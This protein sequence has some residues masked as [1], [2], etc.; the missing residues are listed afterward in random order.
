MTDPADAI[1]RVWH[2]RVPQDLLH[3]RKPIPDEFLPLFTDEA[4][5][6][7]IPIPDVLD[8]CRLV[9]YVLVHWDG[10]KEH[11]RTPVY[12][13]EEPSGKI[14]TVVDRNG[15]IDPDGW[16]SGWPGPGAWSQT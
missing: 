15:V 4:A 16:E 6:E 8:G 7:D 5:W 13:V 14:Y 11:N 10:H 9:R 3:L 1:G 2:K 12:A